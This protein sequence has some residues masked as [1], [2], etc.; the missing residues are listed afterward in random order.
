MNRVKF[1]SENKTEYVVNAT[2][3]KNIDR[4]SMETLGIPSLALMERAALAVTEE[5]GNYVP[6]ERLY[7]KQSL[8]LCGMGNNGGDG[9]AVAR[10]LHILGGSPVIY[11]TG[12]PEQGTE[13]WKTQYQIAKN[14]KLPF[15]TL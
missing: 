5:I 3:M 4:Y 10:M 7:K 11:I 2:E 14:L 6:K 9:L 13:A 8:I 15:C 1:N 12:S